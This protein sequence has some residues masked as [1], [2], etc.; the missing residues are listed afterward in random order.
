ME[1]CVVNQGKGRDC[2]WV[3]EKEGYGL[4]VWGKG[5]GGRSVNIQG[6]G[7]M[8]GLF[9]IWKCGSVDVE[10]EVEVWMLRK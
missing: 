5:M 2:E 9:W 4:R 6:K 10:W 7:T 3:L 8:R 1:K